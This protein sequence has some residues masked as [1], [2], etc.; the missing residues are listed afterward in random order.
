MGERAVDRG[1]ETP[2]IDVWR[3]KAKVCRIAFS[4]AFTLAQHIASC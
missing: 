4:D 2:A 3:A 1:V